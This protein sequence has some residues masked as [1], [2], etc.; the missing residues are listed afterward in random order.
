MRQSK[1]NRFNKIPVENA[2]AKK[3][4]NKRKIS[5]LIEKVSEEIN[6]I[7]RANIYEISMNDSELKELKNKKMELRNAL[8]NCGIGDNASKEFVKDIIKGILIDNHIL[9]GERIEEY[10]SFSN[11]DRLSSRDKFEIIL[12][13]NIET[14]KERAL[15]HIFFENSLFDKKDNT[16]TI[17]END[18]NDIYDKYKEIGI[19][20]SE[21]DKL[22]ILVQRVYAGYKGLGAVDEIRDQKIEG[23]S[24]GV[25]GREGDNNSIWIFIRGKSYHLDFLS[26]DSV[27]ELERVSLNIYR[28]D[29]PGQLSKSK[30]YIV[31]EMKDH[32]RVVVVR[33][34]FAE[35]FA[36]FVRKFDTIEQKNIYDLIKDKGSNVVIDVLKWLIKGCRVCGIT[37]VQGC[38]KTTLLMSLIGIIDPSYNLRIQEMSFELN[39]RQAYPERNILSF[40]ETDYVSGQEGLDIQKKTDGTVNILGEVASNPVAAWMIQMSQVASLFTLFT[41]HAKTTDNLIKYMRNSMLSSNIF[42]D[43]KVAIEQVVEAINFDIHLARDVNGHRYIERITEIVP[44]ESKKGYFLSDIVRFEKGSYILTGN[45]SMKSVMEMSKHFSEDMKEEF[46]EK[47]CIQI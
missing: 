10:I 24:G 11:E 38:G 20:L 6:G 32:S 4:D 42:N 1:A 3:V 36:F 14:Y 34:P 45:F 7:L 37:G 40:R 25:S 19:Y 8:K 29:N 18:I 13:L 33:P 43:E 35:S 30:G 21:D 16:N 17:S 26:F 12:Y 47:Y 15:E 5:E 44:D 41:H 28:Y 31:N 39:L 9:K 27:K 46:Y 22:N 2:A 23:V